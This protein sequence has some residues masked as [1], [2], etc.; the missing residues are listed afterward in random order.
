[1]AGDKDDCRFSWLSRESILPKDVE[2]CPVCLERRF[3]M[4]EK[5]SQPEVRIKP[6]PIPTSTPSQRVSILADI[7]PENL[8]TTL[9]ALRAVPPVSIRVSIRGAA[10][11]VV[12]MINDLGK[13][14]IM[15]SAVV[16]IRGDKPAL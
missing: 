11:R 16:T 4:D 7:L 9:R 8:E 10:S 3:H 12:S 15:D 14:V 13:R 5:K 1:M 2:F 6:E